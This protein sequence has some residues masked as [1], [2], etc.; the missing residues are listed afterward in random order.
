[1]KALFNGLTAIC[2]VLFTAGTSVLIV[3]SIATNQVPA[4]ASAFL[5]PLAL[6]SMVFALAMAWLIGDALEKMQP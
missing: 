5:A 3:Y 6:L 2:V 1:M 4:W